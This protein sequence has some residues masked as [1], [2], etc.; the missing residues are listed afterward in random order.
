MRLLSFI[1]PV[2]NNE[3]TIKPLC[4]D[5]I[6]LCAKQADLDYEIVLVD[7]GS[8]DGSS[9]IIRELSASNSKIRFVKFTSN[10]GQV[11]AITAGLERVNGDAIVIRSADLQD[12]INIIEKFVSGWNQGNKVVIANRSKRSDGMIHRLQ[13]GL[14]Y[15]LIRT[16]SPNMPKGGF[17]YCLIDRQVAQELR[18]FKHRNRFLQGDILSLGFS[19]QFVPY[20]RLEDVN[21]KRRKRRSLSSSLKYSIDGILDSTYLPIRFMSALG[22]ICMLGGVVYSCL[23]VFARITNNVPFEGWAPL[24]ILILL[25]GGML[26]LMMGIMGEYVWRIYDQLKKRPNYIVEE[27][28]E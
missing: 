1:I 23:I 14:F 3:L 16:V 22:V 28:S 24:M 15:K 10:F 11:T 26:M 5:I 6:S 17:D 8:I 21:A 4:L 13:S 27:E 25:I 19:T 20:E 7:D 18:K 2:Y 12:P 9:A